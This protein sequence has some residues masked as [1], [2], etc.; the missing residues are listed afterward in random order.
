M[1]TFRRPGRF[2]TRDVYPHQAGELIEELRRFIGHDRLVQQTA[3]YRS[4]ARTKNGIVV[5]RL[6]YHQPLIE[7]FEE[8]EKATRHRQRPL[9]MIDGKLGDLTNVAAHCHVVAPTLLDTV[10]RHH[11]EKLI[12]LNGQLKPLLLEWKTA[13]HFARAYDAEIAWL[14]V[15][16]TGPEFIARMDGLECEVE[17][18]RQSHMIVELLGLAE[19]D[20]L[21][22]RIIDRVAGTHLR[23]SLL[24]HVPDD[25][26]RSSLDDAGAWAASLASIGDPGE[27]NVELP[28]GLRLEGEVFPADGSGTNAA[29]WQAML[30][31]RQRDDARLYYQARAVGQ[32]AVDPIDL[33]MM[34]PRRNGMALAEYLWDRK[35]SKAAGQCSGA[36]GAVLVFEW[37]TIDDPSIFSESDGFLGLL[38]RTF[39]EHRH[40]AA[41]AM[42]CD[43]ALTRLN[44]VIDSATGAYLAKSEVTNFPEVRDLLGLDGKL[45]KLQR[46]AVL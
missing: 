37:E 17:C 23:G 44:G 9:R 40:V 19:A 36:R 34:G 18:K 31:D 10:E 6:R 43:A 8:Y 20:H 4:T 29:E 5:A 41:I 35:F 1:L 30:R 7:A 22:H 45:R 32:V 16:Q 38:A 46:N 15:D 24:L 42:H 27:V 21:A 2:P 12:D 14:P 33:Q 13:T 26:Q 25:F 39:D 28:G 3:E 11:R